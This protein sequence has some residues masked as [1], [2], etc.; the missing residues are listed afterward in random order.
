MCRVFCTVAVVHFF[1]SH[2]DCELNLF[3]HK[4]ALYSV[5]KVVQQP[6]L[7]KMAVHRYGHTNDSKKDAPRTNN[8]W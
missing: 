7:D 2:Y 3:L 6:K 1:C 5:E 8:K 4:T